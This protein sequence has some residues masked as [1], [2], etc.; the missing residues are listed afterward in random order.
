VSA[1]S[2]P[3]GASCDHYG[4]PGAEW[5]SKCAPALNPVL[6][7]IVDLQMLGM[8]EGWYFLEDAVHIL[9]VHPVLAYG[10]CGQEHAWF[11]NRDGRTRCCE[12][13]EAYLA[14]REALARE[15]AGNC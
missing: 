2:A 1:A 9:L 11:V 4:L 8:I 12:C 10:C 6:G 3:R 14:E 13:D 5:C 7:R 15:R